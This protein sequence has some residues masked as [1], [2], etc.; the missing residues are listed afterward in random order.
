MPAKSGQQF[1]SAHESYSLE[2][3]SSKNAITIT[4]ESLEGSLQNE[5][6]RST[7]LNLMP[8][9]DQRLKKK[10]QRS[11]VI[12]L[13]IFLFVRQFKGNYSQR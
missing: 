10:N 12:Y 13:F 3:D 4:G 1:P 8:F 2:V 7:E 11:V 9:Q 5:V 6:L